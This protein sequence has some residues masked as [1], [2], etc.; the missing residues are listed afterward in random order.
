M[1]ITFSFFIQLMR[2][3]DSHKNTA[4]APLS[5]CLSLSLSLSLSSLF[6]TESIIVR[7]FPFKRV[8]AR[9]GCGVGSIQYRKSPAV[10]REESRDGE[11]DSDNDSD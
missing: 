1:I 7:P 11:D 9:H 4:A 6:F 5:L 10:C 8:E 3:P 2:S